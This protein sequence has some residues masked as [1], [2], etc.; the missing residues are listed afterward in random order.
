LADYL[1]ASADSDGYTF[2]PLQVHS[3]LYVKAG[4]PIQ[5]IVFLKAV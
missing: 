1:E 4:V 2:N 3:K 5:Y